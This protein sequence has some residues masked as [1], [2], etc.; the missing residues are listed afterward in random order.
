MLFWMARLESD[1]GMQRLV[2]VLTILGS[3]SKII[4]HFFFFLLVKRPFSF[5]YTVSISNLKVFKRKIRY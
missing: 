4:K 1:L 2:F 5:V 3:R